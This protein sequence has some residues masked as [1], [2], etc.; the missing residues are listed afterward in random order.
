VCLSS[1]SLGLTDEWAKSRLLC[2]RSPGT[3][4][5]GNVPSISRGALPQLAFRVSGGFTV[6][7]RCRAGGPDATDEIRPVCWRSAP[8]RRAYQHGRRWCHPADQPSGK[9]A[10]I[11]MQGRLLA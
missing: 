8:A 4:K 9:A 2:Q 5:V 10:P 6:L 1:G 11:Q 3:L 7:Q